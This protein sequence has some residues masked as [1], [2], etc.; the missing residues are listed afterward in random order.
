MRFIVKKKKKIYRSDPD[1][2]FIQFY[3]DIYFYVCM[4]PLPLETRA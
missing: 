3:G 4:F 1:S 2:D